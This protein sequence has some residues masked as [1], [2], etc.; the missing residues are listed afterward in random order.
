VI[1]RALI[2]SEGNEISMSQITLFKENKTAVENDAENKLK[3]FS[4]DEYLVHFLNENQHKTETELAKQ[5]GISRKTLWEKR[6][7][8]N[9]P[10]VGKSGK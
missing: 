10:K 4:L 9:I 6:N 2:L 3:A 5:L 1:E 7:R 8:R